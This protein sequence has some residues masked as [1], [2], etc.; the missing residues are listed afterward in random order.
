MATSYEQGAGIK[1]T[2]ISFYAKQQT[3][4][5]NH[6][7]L[8]IFNEILDAQPGPLSYFGLRFS[9]TDGL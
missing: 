6:G 2:R 3:I 5:S 8:V 9:L 1:P 4:V 7:L